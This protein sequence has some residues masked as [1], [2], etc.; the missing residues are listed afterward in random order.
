M[1]ALKGFVVIQALVF[2]WLASQRHQTGSTIH[3]LQ[4]LSPIVFAKMIV[5]F[6]FAGGAISRVL[7]RRSLSRGGTYSYSTYIVHGYILGTSG[8][9]SGRPH[10]G[11]WSRFCDLQ[12]GGN[13]Y[14]TL[15]Y[16]NYLVCC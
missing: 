8:V 4:W 11:W 15:P 16:W 6:W 12:A 9:V 3:D 10:E 7:H 5:V 14:S 1:T 2:L 13:S